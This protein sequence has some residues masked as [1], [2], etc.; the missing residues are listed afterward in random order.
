MYL[1]FAPEGVL[2]LE[3][4]DLRFSGRGT[5]GDFGSTLAGVG[6]INDDGR[7][8]LAVGAPWEGGAVYLFLGE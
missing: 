4:A 8:E 1:F 2:E 5:E 6:D 7:D 3:D